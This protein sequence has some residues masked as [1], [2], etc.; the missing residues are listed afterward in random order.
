MQLIELKEN[1]KNNMLGA[2]FQLAMYYLTRNI[3]RSFKWLTAALDKKDIRAW[4]FSYEVAIGKHP[5]YGHKDMLKERFDTDGMAEFIYANKS[6]NLTTLGLE[7][8]VT[9]MSKAVQLSNPFALQLKECLAHDFQEL[10]IYSTKSLK[11]SLEKY[12]NTKTN[13]NV[14]PD[15][16]NE[17]ITLY[18]TFFSKNTTD[19]IENLLSPYLTSSQIVDPSTGKLSY[20][21]LRISDDAQWY[22]D[23]L[24]LLG[25]LLEIKLKDLTNTE[26]YYGEVFNLIRYEKNGQYKPHLDALP[27]T[28]STISSYGN[29]HTTILIGIGSSLFQGGETSFPKLGYSVKL[30]AGDI[31]FF[32]NIDPTG[33]I[34]NNSIHCGEPV[35]EG[36]KTILSKWLRTKSNTYDQEMEHSLKVKIN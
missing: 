6:F 34:I 23:N 32:S 18:S 7:N 24:G 3:S 31:L 29:R 4:D 35:T 27:L 22:P 10:S 33:H 26:F 15:Y 19:F 21:P 36:C 20:N 9:Y 2:E 8:F 28:D 16:K 13:I 1:Q 17:F 14:I 12:K 5:S 25:L 11:E 30:K